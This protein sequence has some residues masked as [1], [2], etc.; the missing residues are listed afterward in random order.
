MLFHFEIVFMKGV[1]IIYDG[2]NVLGLAKKC[3]GLL[4]EFSTM[5]FNHLRAV[6]ELQPCIRQ[7]PRS[8]SYGEKQT[9]MDYLDHDRMLYGNY[10]RQNAIFVSEDN[11]FSSGCG[12]E[13]IDETVFVHQGRHKQSTLKDWTLCDPKISICYWAAFDCPVPMVWLLQWGE[14][15]ITWV[16][17]LGCFVRF[18]TVSGKRSN[19]TLNV[20]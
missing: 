15:A 20:C 5:H 10:G 11:N 12:G 18:L 13:L 1:C 2:L 8:L 3:S 4:R 19:F 6:Q 7:S 14:R 16:R 9:L 17:R